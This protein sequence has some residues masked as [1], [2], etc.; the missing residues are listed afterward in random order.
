MVRNNAFPVWEELV[1]VVVRSPEDQLTVQLLAEPNFAQDAAAA[2]AAAASGGG[3]DD[4]GE[5][6]GGPIPG[7]GDETR[8]LSQRLR[9][10]HYDKRFCCSR[11]VSLSLAPFAHA[12]LLA[13]QLAAAGASASRPLL[14]R[15]KATW[16]ESEQDRKLKAKES[17]KQA[18]R[19]SAAALKGPGGMSSDAEA[20]R[21]TTAGFA[22]GAMLVRVCGVSGLPSLLW[23]HPAMLAGCTLQLRNNA[24]DQTLVTRPLLEAAAAARANGINLP[25]PTHETTAEVTTAD[26][27]GL[28]LGTADP[29]P[30]TATASASGLAAASLALDEFFVLTMRG[31]KDKVEFVLVAQGLR[32]A[33]LDAAPG[34]SGP[35][36]GKP[37]AMGS[38]SS[39]GEVVVGFATLPHYDDRVMFGTEVGLRVRLVDAIAA[40]VAPAHAKHCVL[41][42]CASWA[43]DTTSGA[44][45]AGGGGGGAAATTPDK[46]AKT[47]RRGSTAAGGAGAAGASAVAMYP[48]TLIVQVVGF[49]CA[50]GA[51][52]DVLVGKQPNLHVQGER[53]FYRTAIKKKERGCEGWAEGEHSRSCI[54]S[55]LFRLVLFFHATPSFFLWLYSTTLRA[56][57][58]LL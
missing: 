10:P 28:N 47:A 46:G 16:E 17:L 33:T 6:G 55:S 25:A 19:R 13:A 20:D 21:A 24:T 53:F 3:A 48:K 4:E 31:A 35:T 8:R 23:Q 45:A 58:R 37:S 30:P 29:P 2:T 7:V 12:P 52:G 11:E 51:D 57:A 14:L 26:L 50:A 44:A 39:S 34:S 43:D 40:R 49:K 27:L 22:H 41:K 32:L 5:G 1:E 56:R 15:L 36:E 9:V 42:I 54:S 38:S 18:R